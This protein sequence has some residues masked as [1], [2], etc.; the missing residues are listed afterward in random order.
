MKLL[1]P[2]VYAM[3]SHAFDKIVL[4]VSFLFL[5]TFS[6]AQN[7]ALSFDGNDSEAD[8]AMVNSF[9]H[10]TSEMTI[11]AWVKVDALKAGYMTLL[12]FNSDNP[13]F[14]FN[15]ND[16]IIYMNPGAIVARQDFLPYV[17]TWTH[18]AVT[19]A[20]GSQRLYI[21]GTEV[22]YTQ[23]LG[24]T[25]GPGATTF[26]GAA[27]SFGI[28]RFTGSD[29]S[30][31]GL[32]D[33]VR[34][35][36]DIR[37][38]SELTANMNA[39]LVGDE[40]G[41]IAYY[42]FNEGS[43]TTVGDLAGT[44]EPGTFLNGSSNTPAADGVTAGPIWST[45]AAPL[46]NPSLT[47]D[48][49]DYVDLGADIRTAL[50][51][52]SNVTVEA[53]VYRTADKTFH[54]IF[55]NY[56]SDLQTLLRLDGNPASHV[57]FWVNNGGGFT[58]ATGSTAIPINTWTHVAG[59]W[60][61]TTIR[62][63]VNGVEDGSSSYSGPFGS[64]GGN[65]Q[66]G[67]DF[68]APSGELFQG[69]IDEVRVWNTTRLE[70]EILSNKDS[71]I[72]PATS[73]LLAYYR[74]NEGSGTSLTD[75]GPNAYN[76]TFAAGANAPVWNTSGPALSGAVP[77]PC[78]DPII[79]EIINDNTSCLV[80]NGALTVVPSTAGGE[81]AGNYTVVI[82]LTSDV[83]MTPIVFGSNVDNATGITA[84]DL[85]DDV[86]TA[87]VINN[88]TGC[89]T[90]QMYAVNNN[91][92]L[93]SIDAGSVSIIFESA[94]G[95]N[96]GGLDA[97]GAGQGGSGS[98]TYNWY[99]DAGLS[100][101]I[102]SAPSISSLASG[103][104]YLEVVDDVTGCISTD[105][106]FDVLIAPQNA[107][108]FDG[109]DDIVGLGNDASFNIGTSFSFETWVRVESLPVG[110]N[111]LIFNK[112]QSGLEDKILAISP[113]G[114]V[115]FSLFNIFSLNSISAVPLDTWVHLA[116]TYD[117]SDARIFIDG[118]EDASMAASGDVADGTGSMY[119]GGNGD[120]RPTGEFAYLDG[121]L[122]EARFWN[123]ARTATEIIGN[124]TN[125]IE[126][127]PGLVSYY[128]FN[129]SGNTSL[130]DRV[131]SNNG[132]L[133]NFD[134]ASTSSDWI[135]STIPSCAPNGKFIG[136][137]DSD[138]SDPSNWCGG[139]VPTTSNVTEDVVVSIDSDIV[140]NEDLV[141]NANDFQVSE[142]TSLTLDLN[143][144]ALQLTNGATFTNNGTVFFEAGT[145]VS[146]VAEN[147]I[148]NGTIS[149][150]FTFNNNFTN[151]VQGTV[152]PGASPGCASFA[153]DFT[154]SGTLDIEVD[155][156]TPCIEHDQI[157]VG[158]TANL[159][160]T[161]NVVLGYTPV[162]GD[163]IIIIDATTISG[164]FGVV[165]LPDPDWSI[166]YDS[167][168]PGQV[169]LNYN[170]PFQV[171]GSNGPGGVGETDGASDLTLWFKADEGVFSDFGVTTINNGGLIQQWND[172]SGFGSN[173]TEATAS[174]KATWN[175]NLA[176]GQPGISYDG[177]DRTAFS[178]ANLSSGADPRMLIAVVSRN[179]GD[180]DRDFF[181]YGSAVGAGIYAVGS[182]GSGVRY[183]V[184]NNGANIE[185]TSDVST[186]GSPDI[187]S[188]VYSGGSLGSIDLFT[189]GLISAI[190]TSAS[191]PN[192]QLSQGFLG[193]S[194]VGGSWD[195]NIFEVIYFN[196]A[197][198]DASRIIVE[199]YLSAKYDIVISN[200][201]YAGDTAP[202]GNYDFDVAGI[203]NT[204][205]GSDPVASSES[206]TLTNGGFLLDDGD[207]VFAGH[208]GTA[209]AF[210][211]TDLPVGYNNRWARDWYID[212]TD[213]GGN[214]GMVTFTFDFA[215]AGLSIPSSNFA[216][217]TRP[218]GSG[219]YSVA[220]TSAVV[221]G[222]QVS[223]DIDVCFFDRW[224]S[225]HNSG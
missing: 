3:P 213:A 130:I 16:L 166:A 15:G 69:Q 29:S 74:M 201:F 125:T 202:N 54:T 203:G 49:A 89:S 160:G 117:G 148:N 35:W 185:N 195:G 114:N 122:E 94:A 88:D 218:T 44:P 32:M 186:L 58:N 192:T 63:Y 142:G 103:T 151:P 77:V 154:N 8:H 124:L 214:N 22:S 182:N 146:D 138:W 126:S 180:V 109:I 23:N 129:N 211:Q 206:L 164:T 97:T 150:F 37:T 196:S 165:N 155:G 5:A 13:Y 197:L 92:S 147:F 145:N 128:D 208:D 42:N 116:V 174:V 189:N 177:A 9:T 10:S 64:N 200:D 61:G 134:F 85:V 40:S 108:N 143:S 4:S 57:T 55:G 188:V 43:G 209:N 73:G 72:D 169:S 20:N 205:I 106:S 198:N 220:S 175:E 2:K 90:I 110:K 204:L 7:Y 45:D 119:L 111:A 18:V 112:W 71:E 96:D 36:D 65:Y 120:G 194:S 38:P 56:G 1:P 81:P 153:A 113:T 59:T 91:A 149:G 123:V 100:I 212:I 217:I 67:G 78:D 50:A 12:D 173:A 27:T 176:N 14:G 171:V 93:P 102:A 210:V 224:P 136:S 163:Q 132:T 199:N 158:G 221:I 225:I 80:G 11:E 95:T 167:P 39:E 223:F 183:R 99:I 17:G 178:D 159:G 190:T 191:V 184:N 140:E 68:A 76:G 70:S 41:L 83:T 137:T 60:D 181:S 193:Q 172:F 47:F 152:A 6:F 156:L 84:T 162:N 31:D 25:L 144:N 48:G 187:T 34:I 131:G 62:V 52:T 98:Y 161:L 157:S 53:W 51:G 33:E 79:T 133:S 107:L 127:S 219:A 118:T 216:L 121:T 24:G 66:I 21:N 86:Y 141:L 46:F 207:Y 75:L 28:G 139:V 115:V 26:A 168:S 30:F 222:D 135:A 82:Y 104:Y 105:Q 87:E 170:N 215:Q 101:P 179:T 19:I